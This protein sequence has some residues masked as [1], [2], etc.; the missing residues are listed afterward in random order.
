MLK[1]VISEGK[2]LIK[3]PSYPDVPFSLLIITSLMIF[4]VL[5]IFSLCGRMFCLYICL[6]IMGEPAVGCEKVV[7]GLQELELQMVVRSCHVGAG[8]SSQCSQQLS[9]FFQPSIALL[10]PQTRENKIDSESYNVQD[11][12][13]TF[14]SCN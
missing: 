2:K 12:V 7:L 11:F 14:L 4:E 5:F 8:K 10:S 6:C 9:D 1:N 3:R 13:A